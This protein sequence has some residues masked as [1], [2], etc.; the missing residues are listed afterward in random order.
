V[1]DDFLKFLRN[2]RGQGIHPLPKAPQARKPMSEFA[3][4]DRY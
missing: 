1:K 2:L 3:H 4:W